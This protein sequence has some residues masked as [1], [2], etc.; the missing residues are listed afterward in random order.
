MRTY[1]MQ[2]ILKNGYMKWQHD[3]DAFSS[4]NVFTMYSVQYIS[5]SY[6]YQ[7]IES[8]YSLTRH[9]ILQAS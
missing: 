8:E 7:V 1:V 4:G 6:I 9:D 3:P 5:P 2:A